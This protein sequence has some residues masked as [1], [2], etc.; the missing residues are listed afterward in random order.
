MRAIASARDTEQIR[1]EVSKD[2]GTRRLRALSSALGR[3]R[4]EIGV[5]SEL[6]KIWELLE[7][8]LRGHIPQLP[9]F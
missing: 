3:L 7:P 4:A 1:D 5:G 8:A 6:H 9:G 2:P